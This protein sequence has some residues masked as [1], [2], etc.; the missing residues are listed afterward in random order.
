M[1][2]GRKKSGLA[3]LLGSLPKELSDSDFR[4]YFDA[5]A[6]KVEGRPNAD[7]W[8][9]ATALIRHLPAQ[10]S[11]AKWLGVFLADAG[12]GPPSESDWQRMKA[13]I[14][15]IEVREGEVS[16]AVR[17]QLRNFDIDMGVL[18]KGLLSGV[19]RRPR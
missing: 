4:L 14:G 5:L 11:L 9:F 6:A 8:K 1:V 2:F 7:Q 16:A 19:N 15:G 17:D 3:A 10:S 12:K 13:H 18:A